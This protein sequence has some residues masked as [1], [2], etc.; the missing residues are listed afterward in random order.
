MSKKCTPLWREAHFQV[1]MYKAQH[2]LTTF[3]AFYVFFSW[4]AQGIVQVVKNVQNVKV[5][6]AV[7][8]TMTSVGHV[9]R[10]SK[11]AFRVASAIQET[12]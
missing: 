8:K 12:Y 7:A 3:D 9:K 5:F 10:V 2:A 6:A 1:K 11:D 4:Q